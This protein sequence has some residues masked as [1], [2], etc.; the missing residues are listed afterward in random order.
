MSGS[1]GRENHP[2]MEDE[3]ALTSPEADREINDEMAGSEVQA[4]SMLLNQ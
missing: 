2:T 3:G 1:A 4:D